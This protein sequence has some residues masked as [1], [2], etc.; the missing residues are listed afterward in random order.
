MDDKDGGQRLDGPH[1]AR[2]DHFL[3]G[4]TLEL[5]LVALED[6]LEGLM[7]IVGLEDLDSEREVLVDS[8]RAMRVILAADDSAVQG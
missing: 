5:D 1:T 6:A 4:I 3:A 2:I 7:K 8:L